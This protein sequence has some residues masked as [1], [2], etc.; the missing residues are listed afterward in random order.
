MRHEVLLTEDA[1]RDLEELY[2]YVSEHDAPGKAEVLLHRVE[3]VMESLTALAE[4]G[5]YPRKLL[6]LG[7]REYRQAFFKPH[8]IIYRVVRPPAHIL[9][10]ADGRRNMQTL[11]ARR[12]LGA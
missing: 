5:S 11:L 6:A 1:E 9:L 10:I 7:M 4:R 8:R 3:Q 12:L 2:N